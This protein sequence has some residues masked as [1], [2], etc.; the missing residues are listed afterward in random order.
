MRVCSRNLG[1]HHLAWSIPS[2]DFHMSSLCIYP[3]I[4]YWLKKDAYPWTQPRVPNEDQHCG[5]WVTSWIKGLKV[6]HLLQNRFTVFSLKL[7][8]K[9]WREQQWIVA[10]LACA[11]RIKTKPHI[12][13]WFNSCYVSCVC[14]CS[15]LQVTNIMTKKETCE[16]PDTT[17]SPGLSADSLLWRCENQGFLK[18]L[19]KT[20]L[21]SM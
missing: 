21:N 11:Q 5:L 15:S 4:W 18:Q 13:C 2:L 20:G 1:I 19:L 6:W 3:P 10:Q 7:V 14:V 16:K 9:C 8:F 12:A 17:K